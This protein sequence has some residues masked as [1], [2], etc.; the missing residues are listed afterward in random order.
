MKN[1]LPNKKGYF[2]G[3]GGR[4]VPETLMPALLELESAYKKFRNDKSFKKKMKELQATY[5]GR[6]TPLYFARRLTERLGGARVYL[7]RED[8][9]HT[10]A[11]KINN[12][13]GQALLAELMGKDR[14]IA[15]T[16]A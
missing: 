13:L 16:G 8:L 2:G 5:I 10:G 6:P 3:F 9:A 11:H 12:A 15:E 1:R 4:Y 14:L 7:K